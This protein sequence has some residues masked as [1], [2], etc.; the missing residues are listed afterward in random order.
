MIWSNITTVRD[1]YGQIMGEP[2]R[3]G[4]CNEKYASEIKGIW[5]LICEKHGMDLDE[6]YDANMYIGA[7][8]FETLCFVSFAYEQKEL[9]R[10][11]LIQ[12]LNKEPRDIYASS[13]PGINIVYE[14]KDYKLL[15][16]EREQTKLADGIKRLAMDY[17]RGITPI[18]TDCNLHIS[19][20]HPA[21]ANYNGYGLARQ[22]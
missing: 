18:V 4:L 10:K 13:M 7:E 2:E 16:I 1:S 8:R 21:M 15:S 17:V 6:F 3:M 14:T 9:V 5:R 19:F 20:F 22:D 12:N 11:Y